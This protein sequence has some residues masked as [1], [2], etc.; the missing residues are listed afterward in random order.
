MD[1]GY[2]FVKLDFEIAVDQRTRTSDPTF[3][4]V[5]DPDRPM[6]I[7]A[8]G[9]ATPIFGPNLAQFGPILANHL[10]MA[11]AQILC[12]L[13]VASSLLNSYTNFHPD[14]TKND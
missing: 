6:P 3:G 11:K 13:L 12:A 9:A 1:K 14:W 2:F 7:G 5:P 4:G 8:L 10:K